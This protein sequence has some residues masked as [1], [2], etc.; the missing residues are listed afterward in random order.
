M[1]SNELE[2]SWLYLRKIHCA[3]DHHTGLKTKLEF[4]RSRD[5]QHKGITNDA[6]IYDKKGR[7]YRQQIKYT[8]ANQNSV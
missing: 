3:A 4:H 7:N 1:Q 6:Y 2:Y 5:V 8:K